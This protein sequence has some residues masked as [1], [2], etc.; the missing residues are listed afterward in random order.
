[1]QAVKRFFETGGQPGPPNG[2]GEGPGARARP[3]RRVTPT[4]LRTPGRGRYSMSRSAWRRTLGG[5]VTPSALAV[6]RLITSSN[7]AGCSIG[8][9]PGLAPFRILAT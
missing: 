1:M 3:S 5:I 4:A 7:L 2:D 8:R 6:L 9:S